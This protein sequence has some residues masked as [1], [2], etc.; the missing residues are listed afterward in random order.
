[1]DVCNRQI[2]LIVALSGGAIVNRL[3]MASRNNSRWHRIFR[4]AL[5]FVAFARTSN[6]HRMAIIGEGVLWGRGQ[7]SLLRDIA[8]KEFF[9]EMRKARPV[10]FIRGAKINPFERIAKILQVDG[11]RVDSTLNGNACVTAEAVRDGRRVFAHV[12]SGPY[13]TS[14]IH[15]HNT[16]LSDARAA[17][18]EPSLL[19]MIAR[20]IGLHVERNVSVFVQS[21]LPGER[22]KP[23]SN[24]G[25]EFTILLLE[26]AKPLIEIHRAT[27]KTDVDP[28]LTLL[29][30]IRQDLSKLRVSSERRECLIW[31]LNRVEQWIHGRKPK[32][33]YVHGDYG[34]HNLL[35]D[36]VERISAIVDWEWARANGCAGYD[37]VHMG[38][39][40]A[41][42]QF[43]HD[44]ALVVASVV[45]GKG[46]PRALLDYFDCILPELDL[47]SDDAKTLALFVWLMVI[48]R[49]GVWTQATSDDWVDTAISPMMPLLMELQ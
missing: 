32:A 47:V 13:G 26:A 40:A 18:M 7:I 44:I 6:T 1:M 30:Q 11:N 19:R 45:G 12:G 14:S 38:I 27:A 33:V 39:L 15:R 4:L 5:S 37:A 46:T 31:A 21:Y 22:T 10:I 20:P 48:F 2:S 24:P 28:E 9:G 23:K 43:N 41:A 49:G 36:S 35:F 17:L 34:V 29:A 3:S 25:S 16:G 8:L 42:G